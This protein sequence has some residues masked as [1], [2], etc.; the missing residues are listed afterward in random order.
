MPPNLALN[1]FRRLAPASLTSYRH[2]IVIMIIMIMIIIIMV[3]IVC[4]LPTVKR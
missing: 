1:D 3:V 2:L 4:V